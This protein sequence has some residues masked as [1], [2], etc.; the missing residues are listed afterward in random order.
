MTIKKIIISIIISFTWLQAGTLDG[1]SN[2]WVVTRGSTLK[3]YYFNATTTGVRIT[4]TPDETGFSTVQAFAE[5]TGALL[6]LVVVLNL[7][8]T[9][10]PWNWALEMV[11]P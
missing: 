1:T 8:L 7:S 9:V 4:F 11:A 5:K 6:I 2:I 3:Q 10:P